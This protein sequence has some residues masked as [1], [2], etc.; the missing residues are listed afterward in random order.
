MLV[1]VKNAQGSTLQMRSLQLPVGKT[2]FHT[3]FGG[4]AKGI[5]WLEMTTAQ[6]VVQRKI[7]VH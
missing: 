4:F 3:D 2:S 6:G 5:Y 7:T 1:S